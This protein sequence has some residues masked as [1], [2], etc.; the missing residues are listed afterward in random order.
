M[1]FYKRTFLILRSY[2]KQLA[3]ASFSAALHAI[4]S[5]MMVWIAGPLMM[6]LFQVENLPLPQT[7]TENVQKVS[8]PENS[9]TIDDQLASVAD[10]IRET[11]KSWVNNFVEADDR[12]D[13]LINFSWLI[14]I[15]VLFKNVFLYIQGFFMAFVQQSVIRKFRNELFAKYQR[16][17]LDYFHRRRTGQIIS[18]VTND[19][20]VLNESIDIGFNR[21]VTDLLMS[22]VLFSF[23]IILSWKLTLLA[24]VVLPIV[25]GFIWFV[26]KKLRKYSERSQE[27]MADVNSV[28]EE[29]ITNMRVV[30]AFAMEN[31]ELKKFFTAT[32]DYFKSLLWMTRIRHLASPINDMLATAA[33]VMILLYAGR[34][35]ISGSGEI[36]AGD[37]MTFIFA[38]FSMIRPV[39]S[40][41]QIHVKLQEGIAAAERIFEVIDADEKIVDT[42]DSKPVTKFNHCISYE[43]VS[44]SYN[45][46]EQVLDNVSFTVNSGEV[47][48]VVGPSGGG[49]STLLDLLPRFYQPQSGVIKIDGIDIQQIKLDSLRNLMGIVTQETLLFNDTIANNI[50]YGLENI[51]RQ[52]IIEAAKMANAHNFIEE[53]EKGYESEVGNRGVMLSGG[54]RQR[55]AIARALLKNPQIL[56]FDEATSALDT[57]SEL[58]VQQAIDRLM[59]GRTVLVIAHR[60]STI[61][62]ADRIIVIDD[63][64]IVESGNHNDLLS[65][66]GLYNRLYSLQFQE[67]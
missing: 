35:I 44:F 23:L 19:V 1:N 60:L 30:K 61:K 3:V 65:N 56:I 45:E 36:D 29:S 13:M 8:S 55:L 59:S 42:P 20:V 6:T 33:G 39:K 64:R 21:L 49:K 38:M 63:G 7:P 2:W 32:K 28:L 54:Q 52:E 57:E 31:F 46:A 4:F 66:G 62:H 5:G 18:R 12:Q 67:V 16:L 17:S 25:F 40:L 58:L 48:A 50:A 51:G 53:F 27:K 26:G 24:M 10:N 11:M 14:L 34:Q 15:I 9:V 22:G 47:V 41:T 37:F 43:A